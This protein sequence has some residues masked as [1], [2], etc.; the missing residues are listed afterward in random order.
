MQFP[1]GLLLPYHFLPR[2]RAL[3]SAEPQAHGGWAHLRPALVQLDIAPNHSQNGTFFFLSVWVGPRAVAGGSVSLLLQWG[4]SRW[5]RISGCCGR[6]EM[7]VQNVIVQPQLLCFPMDRGLLLLRSVCTSVR[8][9]HGQDFSGDSCR[10]PGNPLEKFLS[11]FL[12][13]SL[14]W[15]GN[16]GLKLLTGKG[17]HTVLAYWEL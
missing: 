11:G 9:E 16:P 17:K 1:L 7:A 10:K 5:D 15:S 13:R 4:G 6:R 3:T 8:T 14:R 12:L 2:R